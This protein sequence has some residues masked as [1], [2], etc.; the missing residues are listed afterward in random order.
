MLKLKQWSKQFSLLRTN[1]RRTHSSAVSKFKWQGMIH[2]WSTRSH[3]VW[4]HEE[5]REYGDVHEDP[6]SYSLSRLPYSEC[7]KVNSLSK[8]F[9]FSQW[10]SE[11]WDGW[12]LL[13]TNEVYVD[14]PITDNFSKR[15]S[16]FRLECTLRNVPQQCASWPLSWTWSPYLSSSSSTAFA[17]HQYYHRSWPKGQSATAHR[18]VPGIDLYAD[19]STCGVAHYSL[20]LPSSLIKG[21][22]PSIKP[23]HRREYRNTIH[24]IQL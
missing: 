8:W 23:L 12:L 18:L 5:D 19:T 10:K 24:V 13:D 15:S 3:D 14:L 9:H 16:V 17:Q 7:F 1:W 21:C 4:D 11:G 22:V 2:A 6:S 20:F